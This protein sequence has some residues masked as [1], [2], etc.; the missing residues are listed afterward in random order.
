MALWVLVLLGLAPP[1]PARAQQVRVELDQEALTALLRRQAGVRWVLLRAGGKDRLV[2]EQPRVEVLP[3]GLYLHGRLASLSPE[4]D[5]GVEVRVRPVV[6][7]ATLQVDPE[8]VTVVQPDGALGYLPRTVLTR[9]LRSA[10]GRRELARF[11]LDLRPVMK[12]LGDPAKM[13]IRL[14]LGFGGLTLVVGVK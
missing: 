1:L 8:S 2:F 6:R 4:L 7:G 9:Y 14:R 3:R 10:S 13:T 12:A 5:V 11:S